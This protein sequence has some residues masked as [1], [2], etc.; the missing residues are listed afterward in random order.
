VGDVVIGEMMLVLISSSSVQRPSWALTSRSDR[1]RPIL[2]GWW[3]P[4][5]L[6]YKKRDEV[7]DSQYEVHREPSHPPTKTL[8]PI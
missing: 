7:D 5:V 3:A 4:V 2:H 8:T 1:E 6:C